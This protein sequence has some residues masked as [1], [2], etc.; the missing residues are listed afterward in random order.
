LLTFHF[1]LFAP[2]GNDLTIFPLPQ[3]DHHSSPQND[4]MK[5]KGRSKRCEKRKT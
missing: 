4:F 3:R 1:S 2:G 5:I